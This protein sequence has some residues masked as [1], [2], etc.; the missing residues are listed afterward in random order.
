MAYIELQTA[1]IANGAALSPAVA[2]GQKTLLG[3]VMPA[4]W[5]AA[6]LTFQVS[7]DDT[8]FNELYD[9]AGNAVSITA[10]AGQFVQI[11]PAKW[12]GVTAIK[13]RSGTS[14]AP[15]NQGQAAAIQLVT[16]SVY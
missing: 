2:L 9:G 1:A 14:G 10:A 4:A 3:I 15:V 6:A 16:R 7:I 11:D 13:V 8:T 12:R 5:T